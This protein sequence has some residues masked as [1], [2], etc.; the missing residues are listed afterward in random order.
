MKEDRGGEK[1]MYRQSGHKLFLPMAVICVLWASLGCRRDQGGH[2]PQQGD[3]IPMAYAA[4]LLM[5]ERGG[6][7]DVTMKDPWHEGRILAHY[8]LTADTTREGKDVIHVPLRRAAVFS[9]VHCAL[10]HELGALSSVRGVCDLQYNP[11]P[12]IHS[13][14][15]SG[16]ISHLG[17][18]VEP[19]LE[20][21]IDMMPDAIL[22]SPY[23]QN[24]GY[25]KLG[26]LN[27]PL[28][29]CADYMEVSALARAEWIRFYGRLVG[30]AELADSIFQGVASRYQQ[31]KQQAGHSSQR[32]RLIC[33][34]P[35]NGQWFMPAGGSP[36]GQ[37]YADA[38][39]D[40]LFS[41]IPGTG[42]APLSIEHVL[43]RALGSEIWLVKTYGL[44]SKAQLVA[45]TPLLRG[46]RA[47]VWTCDPYEMKF[48][49]ETPFH[50]DLLLENLVALL[51]PQLGISPVREYFHRVP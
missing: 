23:E 19:N 6:D 49:E 41:D 14:V 44:Q 48:Y 2:V 20:R 32:P 22:R 33:E 27:I 37:M 16:R 12:Y 45:D 8:L 7:I 36:M 1:V 39:A 31:L 43:E 11:L 18:S 38:G 25:G 51:H 30:K 4:N 17:N 10:F 9:S 40:Y 50:P 3:T 24:G 35:Y 21:L 47:Q 29:E 13:G 42:S 15:E 46:I 28:V 34:A 26:K 5:V